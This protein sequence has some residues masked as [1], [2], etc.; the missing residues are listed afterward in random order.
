MR[1]PKDQMVSWYKFFPNR[2][3]GQNESWKIMLHSGWDKFFEHVIAGISS[4]IVQVNNNQN[5]QFCCSGK[6]LDD[7]YLISKL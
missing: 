5:K 6:H 1:N 7:A 2:P 4:T 3:Q